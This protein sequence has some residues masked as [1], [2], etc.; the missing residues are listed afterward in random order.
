MSAVWEHQTRQAVERA[1]GP[2]QWFGTRGHGVAVG[3]PHRAVRRWMCLF[4]ERLAEMIGPTS[5]QVR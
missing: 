3:P 1:G 5:R 4:S 2:R